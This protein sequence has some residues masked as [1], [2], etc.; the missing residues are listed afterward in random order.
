MFT[1]V[2]I[3]VYRHISSHSLEF[4]LINL[5]YTQAYVYQNN[6]Y[7]KQRPED[8]PFQI[9]YNGRENKIFN[10]I[11]DWVYEGKLFF[12]LTPSAYGLIKNNCIM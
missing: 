5:P 11:P 9:T 1:Y 2:L 12:I 6:I 7:L 3:C 4:I 8:P 10:G